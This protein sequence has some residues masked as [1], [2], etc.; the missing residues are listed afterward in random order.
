M[1]PTKERTNQMKTESETKL[2]TWTL[3][4]QMSVFAGDMPKSEV[5]SNAERLLTSLLDGTD[6]MSV[7][8]GNAK[9]DKY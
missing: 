6:F 4:V 5:I 9:R 7:Y 8:V 2:D 3:A 1:T